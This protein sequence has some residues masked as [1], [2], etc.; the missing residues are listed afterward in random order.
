MLSRK[1]PQCSAIKA[2]NSNQKCDSSGTSWVLPSVTSLTG[3]IVGRFKN[4][5]F[6]LNR[7]SPV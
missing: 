2:G 7:G 4:N 6:D 1:L 5:N 3:H